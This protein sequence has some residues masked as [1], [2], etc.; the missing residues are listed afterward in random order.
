[1]RHGASLRDCTSLAR[2]PSASE[3][4]SHQAQSSQVKSSE[5]PSASPP[6][7]AACALATLTP[8]LEKPCR[9]S[10]LVGW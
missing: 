8:P 9:A 4:K 2:A 7:A 5:A 10:V 6:T 3:V 1:M